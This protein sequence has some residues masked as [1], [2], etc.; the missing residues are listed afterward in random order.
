MAFWN[1][2]FGISLKR[3]ETVKQKAQK[4]ESFVAPQ[5]IDGALT[6]ESGAFGAGGLLQYQNQNQNVSYTS[7]YDLITRYRQLATQP[8]T[9]EAINHIA[10]DAII[11]DDGDPV[12]IN[13][14]NVPNELVPH[15]IKKRIREEF[16]NVLRLLDYRNM[17][18]DIFRTWYIDGK[19]YYHAV[20][21]EGNDR[22]GI[23]ELKYIDPRQIRKVRQVQKSRD[24]QTGA[25]LITVEQEY[26]VYS[27]R[28]YMNDPE[29]VQGIRINKDAVVYAHS[30][31]VDE[32]SR[33]IVSFLH[34]AIRPV[35]QLRMIEDA[36]VIYRISRAPERRIFYVDTGNLPVSKAQEYLNMVM[37][38][39]RSKIVYNS[40]T[41][42][43]DDDRRY[44]SMM[45][46][47]WIP[48]QEGST[49]TEITTL[50]GGQNLGDIED[51]NYFKKQV[52]RA[53]NVPVS[54]L[55]SDNGFTLGRAS[56]ISRDEV[57]FAKFIDRLRNKFSLLFDEILSKNLAL[58]G[59]LKIEEW[60]SV[61]NDIFYEFA[62]DSFFQEL[63]DSEILRERLNNLDQIKEH[64][65]EYF[66]KLWIRKNVLKQTED[67]IE[68][69]DEEIEAEKAEG[70]ID[71]TEGYK[72][73]N[74]PFGKSP[75]QIGNSTNS[76]NKDSG[77]SSNGILP[78]GSQESEGQKV[79]IEFKNKN[80]D[81]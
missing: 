13:L 78:D 44:V 61:R 77:I 54:R 64:R 24:T 60:E 40:Q 34:K 14:D 81:E 22:K 71:D 57:N 38:N 16:K 35:N 15:T 55:E 68:E 42:E 45:E 74:N 9:D 20:T 29:F 25:D 8:E 69:I 79:T 17:G 27:P 58:K 18:H 2:L 11:L 51:I 23:V 6:V 76:I 19:I 59:I 49:G 73:E 28:G 12:T 41:G 67:D 66:S 30:G 36:I 31:L 5:N 80:E 62:S 52:L 37:S 33:F 72:D 63:K 50:P 10:N 39:F 3:K 1:N 43:V 46:D 26:F 48:R 7:E 70:E 56:E 4:R 32:T 21:E 75:D 47:F 65:G 53:L